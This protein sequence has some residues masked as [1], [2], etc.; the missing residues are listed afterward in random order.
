MPSLGTLASAVL[1][2]H[3]SHSHVRNGSLSGTEEWTS[4][5]DSEGA[6]AKLEPW[7]LARAASA[8]AVNGGKTSFAPESAETLASVNDSKDATSGKTGEAQAGDAGSAASPPATDVVTGA[9]GGTPD[10]GGEAEVK[11]DQGFV[12]DQGKPW[13]E[14]LFQNWNFGGFEAV[15]KQR[16]DKNLLG[17]PLS[18]CV[19]AAQSASGRDEYCVFE[20]E[21]RMRREAETELDL[22]ST[23]TTEDRIPPQRRMI[24]VADG[25]DGDFLVKRRKK[26][27]PPELEQQPDDKPGK[28]GKKSKKSGS[29][30]SP[31]NMKEKQGGRAASAKHG[32]GDSNGPEGGEGKKESVEEQMLMLNDDAMPKDSDHEISGFAPWLFGHLFGSWGLSHFGGSREKLMAQLQHWY[33]DVAAFGKPDT[34]S[35]APGGKKREGRKNAGMDLLRGLSANL[36][37]G[38]SGSAGG[39]PG[40]PAVRHC[41]GVEWYFRALKCAKYFDEKARLLMEENAQNAEEPHTR[42]GAKG[43]KKSKMKGKAQ[44]IEGNKGDDASEDPDS[45]VRLRRVPRVD[46]LATNQR[47]ERYHNF[48]LNFF[49][50]CNKTGG[51]DCQPRDTDIAPEVDTP[52]QNK[53]DQ[54][55]QKSSSSNPHAVGDAGDVGDGKMQ[56][57]KSDEGGKA[58]G[59]NSKNGGDEDS[60]GK[61]EL[62]EISGEE[63]DALSEGAKQHRILRHG[64]LLQELAEM[65]QQKVRKQIITGPLDDFIEIDTTGRLSTKGAK[66][67]EELE[68]KW[69]VIVSSGARLALREKTE[70]EWAFPIKPLSSVQ[71]DAA[72][73]HR[74]RWRL[75]EQVR[76]AQE[77]ERSLLVAYDN[78]WRNSCVSEARS[79]GRTEC[80]RTPE[81]SREIRDLARE[82]ALQRHVRIQLSTRLCKLSGQAQVSV[83]ELE[84]YKKEQER[85]L[86][87]PWRYTAWEKDTN[88]DSFSVSSE[89]QK[90][91]PETAAK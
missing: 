41:V 75:G 68:K 20:E 57:G 37:A 16:R 59:K 71:V 90:L 79:G 14:F 3:A 43:N 61:V 9:D 28:R 81:K 69:G 48:S 47:V 45:K 56:H 32:D 70:C 10:E 52:A 73:W 4:R 85:A 30:S 78:A 77:K 15:P 22:R 55:S 49:E 74:E 72:K 50:N 26:I 80:G 42:K 11:L 63:F 67:L 54:T 1:D 82:L 33:G 24:C 64:R 87:L 76:A 36:Y 17:D 25:V 91:L 6:P 21:P 60:K 51:R 65:E 27:G 31:R 38:G 12:D 86:D 19:P 39:L 62:A 8:K 58:A 34:A 35:K 7:E 66:F 46:V 13:W 53:A 44:K 83:S 5:M 2:G 18:P 40:R 23:D 29:K 88:Y 84:N 89:C